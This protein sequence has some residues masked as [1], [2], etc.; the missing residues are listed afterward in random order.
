M[1]TILIYN[2]RPQSRRIK[3]QIPYAMSD[4]RSAFKS[5]EGRYY[6]TQQKLWSIENTAAN[7]ELLK[8]L[9]KNRYRLED[10]NPSPKMPPIRLNEQSLN[11]LCDTEQKLL[12][13]AYSTHTVKSYKSELGCFFKY[14]ETYD[15]KTVTKEQ[16]E[17]YF[18][19]LITKYKIGESK[20]NT[21]INA[22][23]FYYEQVLG[24]PREYYNIQRP[25]E[26]KT[27]PNVLSPE[28]VFKL[29][30]TPEN[31]KHRAMLY[32]LYGGGLRM[33]EL[34]NLRISD[35]RSDDGY[36]FI[37]GAKG[38]KD[39][40]TLLPE[41]L[42]KLLRDYY[43][44]YKPSYWLFEGQ[45]GGKYSAKSVQNI[46]RRAQQASGVNPWS[47]PHTL[48]HSFATHLLQNGENLRNI[49]AL[50]G[51]ESSKTTEVYTHIMNVTN[52]NIKNPLDILMKN[53]TFSAENPNPGD[54]KTQNG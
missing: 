10:E 54:S 49:Q 26:S 37:K 5:I 14:F 31:L 19:Y 1:S 20:Q 40:R 32:T 42:L 11:A 53:N 34:L 47:T 16:I 30:N 7:M 36:I 43:K 50:L 35:I 24:M 2:P 6:H 48:R 29:I 17:G 22:V 9:F 23:K 41:S 3:V 52:K 12:L 38:K 18:H 51:H 33:S 25:K 15:L 28:E 27:L 45:D 44:S 21:G 4:E 13:K 39:R 8:K 46:F